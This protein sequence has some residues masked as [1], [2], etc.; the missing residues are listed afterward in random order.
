MALVTMKSVLDAAAKGHYAV[1]AFGGSDMLSAMSA[2]KAAEAK[3]VPLI[4]LEEFSLVFDD[5]RSLELHFAALNAMAEK[6]DVPVATV[7]DHGMSYE[8]CMRA[9][10]LGC[11]SVMFDGSSLPMEENIRITKEIVKIAHAVG[12]SVEG[13]IGHVGGTEGGATLEGAEVDESAYSTPE[14]ARYFAEET[15]V[16]AL[17]VAIGTVHGTFKG[18]PKL[19]IERLKDIRKAVGALP[20]VLHGGSGLSTEQFREAIAGGINKINIFKSSERACADSARELLT[21]EEKYV[22]TFDQI[23][24]DAIP[25]I[26]RDVERHIDIFQTPSV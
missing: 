23:A 14:E 9:I 13:E 26:Q 22:V 16:D 3:K 6:A 18:T 25:V 12:V 10:R 15:G 17:A 20:L 8:D 7:L 2:I 21:K 5:D 11:T 24:R 19:D 4:L 1:G